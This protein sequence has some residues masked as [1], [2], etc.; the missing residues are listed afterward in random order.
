MS[1]W[2]KG[3]KGFSSLKG[4]VIFAYPQA[5]KIISSDNKISLNVAQKLDNQIASG[6]SSFENSEVKD[7]GNKSLN[8]LVK[9]SNSNNCCDN[10]HGSAFFSR[11]NISRTT[12]SKAQ[13]YYFS[14]ISSL[15]L[16]ALFLSA[17][18][19]QYDPDPVR[20]WVSKFISEDSTYYP[21]KANI[22]ADTIFNSFSGPRTARWSFALK[23]Y[24]QEYS[25]FKKI[26]GSG[27]N[28][29]NW[30]G[31]AFYGDKKRSDYP[32]NPFL[33]VLLYSGILGLFIYLIFIYKVFQYYIKYFK[34]YKIL[35]VFFIITFF[36]SFFSAGSPFDPPIMGFFVI[37]PF[38]IHSVH[39]KIKLKQSE[40]NAG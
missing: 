6:Y 35:S 26:F 7:T 22:I 19:P 27:F 12:N 40:N 11:L 21:L 15:P 33:S 29:L 32:H 24:T 8:H 28:F 38:F 9:T 39:K 36:F 18:S 4:Y 31:Y 1:F 30:Y 20:N 34:E 3:I 23:I 14:S 16:S 13:K 37:L 5:D 2:K 17:A 10:I 25:W